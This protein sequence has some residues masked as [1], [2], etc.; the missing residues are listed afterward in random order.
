MHYNPSRRTFLKSTGAL[1]AGAAGAA[2]FGLSGCSPSA[3]AKE[4][5]QS[6]AYPEGFSAEDYDDSCVVFEP[7]ENVAEEKTYDIVVVGAGTSGMPAVLTALEEGAS[8]ACL[9]KEPTAIAQ[10][11]GDGGICLEASTEAGV[12]MWLQEWRKSCNYRVN[13]DLARFFAYHSGE[14]SMWMAAQSKSAGYAPVDSWSL[15]IELPD[16]HYVTQT[17]N[18]FGVKPEN[19][20][21]LVRALADYAE[22][23]GADP[24]YSTPG[25]Q[26]VK[27][28]NR[29]VGVIGKRKDGSYIRFN[30]TKAVILAT[31]DYQNNGSMI[32]RF[33]PDLARF[34][35]KQTNKT[36]DG[37]LMS[38]AV[39]GYMTPVGHS[40][41]MHDMDAG[42]YM[43]IDIPFLS[44]NEEGDRFMNEEV[45]MHYW[46]ETLRF[47]AAEDPGKFSRIFDNNYVEAAT[48][49]GFKPTDRDS[50]LKYVPGAV[51][52]PEG[53]IKDLIDTHRCDTLDEL[54]DELGIPADRLKKSVDRYNELCE[55]G[56]DTDFGKQ[57]RYLAPIVE[58]PF[59]GIHQWIRLTAMCCGV[60]VDGNY[61]VV[62]Q[63]N[64]QIPGLYAVG[65]GAGDLCGDGDWSLHMGNMSCG[66]CMTSGR[67][68][69]IHALTGDLVPSHPASWEA[70]MSAE[71][72]RKDEWLA[73]HSS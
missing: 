27:D 46:D 11:G 15:H 7:I 72:Y 57:Q 53:V 65:F 61:Q 3:S 71:G 5:A 45:P 50:L 48:S 66:S 51:D 38:A 68:A 59:W 4:P 20:G 18:A 8:V 10:G 55:Q 64:N 43:M 16:G 17:K 73:E 28:E 9:Q 2:A 32:S 40:K 29:V 56:A 13:M 26:L 69:T 63:E 67:Y 22:S 12:L 25:V 34:T 14:T 62:D 36:G 60:A 19:N 37:I 52:N 58:P 31:G 39:G 21:N 33:A 70:T 41:Q 30:A 44:V 47:Q 54:A 6:K 24:Y 49:W 42:P 1:A 23:L 35:C